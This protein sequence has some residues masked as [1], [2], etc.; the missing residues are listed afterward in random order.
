MIV[1]FALAAITPAPASETLELPSHKPALE[2]VHYG[3]RVGGVIGQ[4]A[5][6]I[7]LIC[8]DESSRVVSVQVFLT[9]HDIVAGFTIEVETNGHTQ[10]H[11][12]GDTTAIA[13]SKFIPDQP[14]TIVGISGASGWFVDSLRFHFADGSETPLYGGS[15]GDLNYRLFLHRNPTGNLRGRLIGFWG[16]HTHQLETLGLVFMALE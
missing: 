15:G 1:V 11:G 4:E 14:T 2:D 12:F 10:H 3:N 7:E 9:Q 6:S 5:P 13:R 16:S 8:F